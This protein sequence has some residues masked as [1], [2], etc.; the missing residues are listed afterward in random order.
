MLTYLS[1]TLIQI[2]IVSHDISVPVN[3]AEYRE[4]INSKPDEESSSEVRVSLSRR[5]DT[6]EAL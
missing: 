1:A 2:I 3:N 4:P 5:N 6:R